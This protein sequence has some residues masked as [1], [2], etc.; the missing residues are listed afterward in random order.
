MFVWFIKIL[1]SELTPF[2]TPVPVPSWSPFPP[3]PYQNFSCPECPT[4]YPIPP[5]PKCPDCICSGN[6]TCPDCKPNITTNECPSVCPSIPPCP[7][8]PSLPPSPTPWPSP[9]SCP[10]LTLREHT[11]GCL[12]NRPIMQWTPEIYPV[13]LFL[14]NQLTICGMDVSNP[15]FI[16]SIQCHEIN[17]PCL[18]VSRLADMPISYL[19]FSVARIIVEGTATDEIIVSCYHPVNQLRSTFS[20]IHTEPSFNISVN[21]DGASIYVNRVV[22]KDYDNNNK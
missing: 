19:T 15:Q 14:T 21:G 18:Y 10:P 2:P 1:L 7:P 6:V 5:C 11:F 12:P 8:C 3:F 16:S 17:G 20:F 4:P 22:I 13:S 9:T